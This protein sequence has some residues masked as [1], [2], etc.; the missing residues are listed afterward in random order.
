MTMVTMRGAPKAK[1]MSCRQRR[2]QLDSMMEYANKSNLLLVAALAQVGGEMILKQ[3]T[4]DYV[5]AHISTLGYDM[6]DNN[7]L[8]TEQIIEKVAAGEALPVPE[9]TLRLLGDG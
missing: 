5:T 4:L 7:T 2:H 9:Y 6:R 1:R 3:S 8:T